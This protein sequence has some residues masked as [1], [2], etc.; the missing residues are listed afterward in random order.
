MSAKRARD[1]E[2][3][4]NSNRPDG[5]ERLPLTATLSDTDGR[6]S[7]PRRRT[8]TASWMSWMLAVLAASVLILTAFKVHIAG[9]I[10]QGAAYATVYEW[11]MKSLPYKKIKGKLLAVPTNDTDEK[12]PADKRYTNFLEWELPGIRDAS[13][14]LR[15]DFGVE[16]ES[17]ALVSNTS[18]PLAHFQEKLN[19]P[20]WRYDTKTCAY[21]NRQGETFASV[22]KDIESIRSR[23]RETYMDVIASAGET[24]VTLAARGA[25]Q[26]ANLEHPALE[27]NGTHV[28][29]AFEEMDALFGQT[30]REFWD[31]MSPEAMISWLLH[32]AQRCDIVVPDFDEARFNEMNDT[33]GDV[34]DKVLQ[35]WRGVQKLEGTGRSITHDI[36]LHVAGSLK[37]NDGKMM[38]LVSP[39]H[40]Y[41]GV[42]FQDYHVLGTW[43]GMRSRESQDEEDRRRLQKKE[44]HASIGHE[45]IGLVPTF[46]SRDVKIALPSVTNEEAR[47]VCAVAVACEPYYRQADFKTTCK[48]EITVPL[49]GRL[50]ALDVLH[51]FVWTVPMLTAEKTTSR[52]PFLAS[53]LHTARLCQASTTHPILMMNCAHGVGHAVLAD[54]LVE[55]TVESMTAQPSVDALWKR[56]LDD[57]RIITS[58]RSED[59]K[60]SA[61]RTI[62]FYTTL[63]DCAHFGKAMDQL[64]GD[65]VFSIASCMTG[66]HHQMLVHDIGFKSDSL[67]GR[68]TRAILERMR[69]N[70][71]S[72]ALYDIVHRSLGDKDI[73]VLV[74]MLRH[75]YM[76]T[77]VYL[78]L[79]MMDEDMGSRVGANNDALK[80]VWREFR[81][82][83][84]VGV[85]SC[86]FNTGFFASSPLLLLDEDSDKNEM[87]PEEDE[88]SGVQKLVRDV[89]AVCSLNTKRMTTQTRDIAE[90]E[91]ELM[92][93]MLEAC[94]ALASS[95]CEDICSSVSTKKK[96]DG[97]ED[98]EEEE[99]EEEQEE[100]EEEED[101]MH[102]CRNVSKAYVSPLCWHGA[103]S[104]ALAEPR[105]AFNRCTEACRQ[106]GC[107]RREWEYCSLGFINQVEIGV[108]QPGGSE[109]AGLLETWREGGEFMGQLL[110]LLEKQKVSRKW[111]VPNAGTRLLEGIH[112]LERY[113]NTTMPRYL[114]GASEDDAEDRH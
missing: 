53:I 21:L 27:Y 45:I 19:L 89:M 85:T 68:A 29:A 102:R 65:K 81:S 95:K 33:D 34:D 49:F 100:E 79:L 6:S 42:V 63:L 112:A 101:C 87:K 22:E 107:S 109:I 69:E 3:W 24:R 61:D 26:N 47:A 99:E 39:T 111:A 46:A 18:D 114:R 96:D 59:S 43:I 106:L 50:W 93:V 30:W 4:N 73:T 12:D 60:V 56:Y 17:H 75:C 113:K 14:S 40:G 91:E 86:F 103:G 8:R 94:D 15:E 44:L 38:Q 41:E 92:G 104:V 90:Q 97:D 77:D 72:Q 23:F 62:D 48:D 80:H 51:A 52:A 20:L 5:N 58:G 28:T 105:V 71:W 64:G 36:L 7:S 13:G 98:K 67:D 2:S 32:H 110:E 66:V 74:V 35:F 55:I 16:G 31:D 88:Y 10:S 84:K 70:K 83:M 78:E 11:Q 82:L 37:E 108:A 1:E 57:S 9:H 25:I 76:L 54:T